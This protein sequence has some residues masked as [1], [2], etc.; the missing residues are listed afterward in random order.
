MAGK[1]SEAVQEAINKID[2]LQNE[3]ISLIERKIRL[4]EL[5]ERFKLLR[6]YNKAEPL[7]ETVETETESE[8]SEEL[9]VVR[10]HLE[11]L[12]LAPVGTPVSEL[13]RLAALK[14]MEK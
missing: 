3:D 8:E 6:L 10:Q 7:P 1:F 13:A 14:V 4:A 11:S 9:A 12:K 5:K 2:E